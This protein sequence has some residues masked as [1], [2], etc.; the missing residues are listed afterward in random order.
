MS[1]LIIDIASDPTPSLAQLKAAGIKTIFGYLSSINPAGEKCWTASR[2]KI[3]AAAG[4][5]I[6]LVHEGWGGV[7]GRG[8]SAADGDRDGRYCRVAAAAL[9]APKGACVYFACDADFSLPEIHALVLPYFKAIKKAFADGMYRVGVYGSGAVCLAV[10]AADLAD[11]S[12]EAQ[13]RGWAGYSGWL[14]KANMTQGPET[15]LAGLDIDTD[16]AHG[17]IGDFVPFAAAASENTASA[18]GAPAL[19][20]APSGAEL[21]AGEAALKAYVQQAEGWK[22][23]FVPEQA[24][25]TGASDVIAA[26]NASADQS[27]AGRQAAGQKALRAA[28]DATG[29]GGDVTDAMC[30]AGAAAV[31]KAIA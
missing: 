29:Y 17:D 19:P 7:N 13:S 10:M 23:A 28:I 12:W 20:K 18:R 5:R 15:K 9:G 30:T 31:L 11:L 2:V 27:S 25:V 1:V 16:T 3:A 6:G 4:F 26:A 8:I 24:Y 21:A 14:A 22:A